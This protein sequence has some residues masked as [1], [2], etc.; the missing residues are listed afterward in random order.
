MED[1]IEARLDRA[2]TYLNQGLL[3]S[4]GQLK[5]PAGE[6]QTSMVNACL[7][8]GLDQFKKIERHI[9]QSGEQSR[10]DGKYHSI[11]E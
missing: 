3:Y 8:A 7:K 9:H 6:T 5:P 1:Y 10:E 4:K 2:E 11:I